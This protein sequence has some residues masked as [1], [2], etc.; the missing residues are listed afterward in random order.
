MSKAVRGA[1]GAAPSGPVSDEPSC[2]QPLRLGWLCR[3]VRLSRDLRP[4][5]IAEL[6]GLS[7]ATVTRF[8]AGSLP[9]RDTF[10]AYASALCGDRGA[11]RL[12]PEH[13]AFLQ[14][15]FQA[16]RGAPAAEEAFRAVTFHELV[17]P[18]GPK[19]L[20]QLLSRLAEYPFPAYIRDEL[21]FLH[22]V[23]RGLHGLYGLAPASPKLARWEYWHALGSVFAPGSRVQSMHAG[24]QF[25]PSLVRHFAR[26]ALPLLFTRQMAA[27]S[28][29]LCTLSPDGFCPWWRTVMSLLLPE[30]PDTLPR[31]LRMGGDL[32]QVVV[33]PVD[34]ASV[35]TA[36]GYRATFTLTAWQPLCEATD[37]LL[38]R[39]AGLGAHLGPVL[40]ADYEAH[41]LLH[42]NDWPEMRDHG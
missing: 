28:S 41:G 38:R 26:T 8:E 18:R 16:A 36:P 29:R 11:G 37:A 21:F 15:A 20:K 1:G 33:G 39:A 3:Q 22:A 6:S 5:D 4:T 24:D 10:T 13:E 40:A 17:R 30:P 25:A 35:E 34:S 23:N 12:A 42:V 19:P 32:A 14:A 9:E 7:V 2:C 27:L 31:T